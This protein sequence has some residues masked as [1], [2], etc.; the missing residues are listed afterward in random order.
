MPVHDRFQSAETITQ[1]TKKV[2]I[3]R[4]SAHFDPDAPITAPVIR[5][6]KQS[7]STNINNAN[8]ASHSHA[9]SRLGSES[10]TLTTVSEYELP[11]DPAW[12]FPRS[13]L[14]LCETLGEGAFGKVRLRREQNNE[15]VDRSSSRSSFTNANKIHYCLICDIRS[16]DTDIR[17]GWFQW[18]PP[19]I[20]RTP[21]IT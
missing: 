17:Q 1:W 5:I 2:I 16:H 15:E 19:S 6:E 14:K 13:D 12:E 7:S 3:E 10:T 4:Q 8:N 18:F 20:K 9:K 11:L 21:D